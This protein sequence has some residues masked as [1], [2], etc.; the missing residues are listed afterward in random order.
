MAFSLASTETRIS[1]IGTCPVCTARL[2]SG[3]LIIEPLLCTVIESLPPVALATSAANWTTFLVW[4]LPS[5]YGVG[6]S[7][8]V[9][10]WAA[11]Q[12]AAAA[13]AAANFSLMIPPDW[14]DSLEKCCRDMI[15]QRERRCQ[16]G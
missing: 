11:P 12:R 9:C 16:S 3:C 2:I 6:M 5:G 14:D 13:S 4:K 8:L 7:H 10:A 15:G 1:P